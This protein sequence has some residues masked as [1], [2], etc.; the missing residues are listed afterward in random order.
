MSKITALT[1]LATLAA[2]D[3]LCVVDDVAGTATTKK[4]A[5]SVLDGRYVAVAGDTMTEPLL[6]SGS[7]RVTIDQWI[8]ATGVR[9]PGLKK[10]TYVL[11][12]LTGVWQFADAGAGNE[13]QISGTLKISTLMDRTVV[14][15]MTIGWSADGVSPGNC[16]WQFE[17]LWIG[18]DEATD[19][20]AQKTLTVTTAASSTSNGLVFS[21]FAGIDLPGGTDQAMLFRVTRLS[22]GGNDTIIDSVELRGMKYTYTSDKLGTGV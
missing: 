15:T 11:H 20:A 17:Y 12:G 19:A 10:A 2:A 14:P 6:F 21:T 7:G 1:N 8:G 4:L 9:A 13:Q 16:E 18:A 5:V 3:L 22:A